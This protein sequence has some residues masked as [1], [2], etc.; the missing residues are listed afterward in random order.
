MSDMKHMNYLKEVVDKDIEVLQRKEQTYKGSWK[1][2]GGIGAFMMMARKWDRLEGMAEDGY[3]YDIFKMLIVSGN[4][5][6]G[7]ALAEVRDLRRYLLLIEAE[8]IARLETPPPYGSPEDGGH[9]SRMK[10]PT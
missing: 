6:D 8:F 3:D 4:G 10:D 5:E 2:R 7:T 1:K 9:H